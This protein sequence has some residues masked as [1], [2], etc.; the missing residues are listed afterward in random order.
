MLFVCVSYVNNLL[1][2]I[3]LDLKNG[4]VHKGKPKSGKADAT[5]TLEDKDMVEIVSWSN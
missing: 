4:E 3:A 1:F 2:L 5:L